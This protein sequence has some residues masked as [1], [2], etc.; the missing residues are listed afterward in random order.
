MKHHYTLAIVLAVIILAGVI[1]LLVWKAP[2]RS[3]GAQVYDISEG[4]PRDAVT[5]AE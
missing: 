3:L 5:A 2:D 4:T 1:F